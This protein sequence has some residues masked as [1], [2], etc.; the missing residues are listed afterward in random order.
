MPRAA[1]ANTFMRKAI[2][3]ACVSYGCCKGEKKK[4]QSPVPA[5]SSPEKPERS[6]L[7]AEE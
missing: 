3:V 1:N 4:L 7:G 6:G 2:S 5:S